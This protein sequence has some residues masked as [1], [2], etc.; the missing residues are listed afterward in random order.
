M[1]PDPPL[2]GCLLS[3]GT[4]RRLT[5]RVGVG[6]GQFIDTDGFVLAAPWVAYPDHFLAGVDVTELF[7]MAKD[8]ASRAVKRCSVGIV[9]NGSGPSVVKI[10]Q[11]HTGSVAFSVQVN[12]S[13]ARV[14]AC[15]SEGKRVL[16]EGPAVDTNSLSLHGS[17]LHWVDDGVDRSAW[18]R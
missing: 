4:K 9:V 11:K 1:K 2:F 5:P 3:T 15:D 12:L 17:E 6:R 14:V 16:D 18:L 8:I 13:T 10:V 7:V